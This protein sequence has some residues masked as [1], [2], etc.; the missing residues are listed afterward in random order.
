MAHKIKYIR[1]PKEHH[2]VVT[3][4]YEWRDKNVHYGISVC[5][6]SDGHTKSVGRTV[7]EGRLKKSLES[8]EW[9]AHSVYSDYTRV[10][11]GARALKSI[12]QQALRHLTMERAKRLAADYHRGES[13][14]MR[15]FPH[16]L[17]RT[18]NHFLA[19]ETVPAALPESHDETVREIPDHRTVPNPE[20]Y[21]MF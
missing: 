15:K 4:A 17:Q 11:P 2:R 9:D 18:L 7:A 14:E 19:S 12:V 6:P 1:D 16:S 13:V 3:I 5:S 10:I 21:D 20:E 8:D